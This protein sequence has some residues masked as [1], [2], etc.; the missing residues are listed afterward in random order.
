LKKCAVADFE[1]I[2]ANTT[3]VLESSDNAVFLNDLLPFLILSDRYTEHSIQKSRGS[4]NQYVLFS[5]IAEFEFDLPPLDEQHRLAEV[6]WAFDATKQAYK[7]LLKSTDELVK[8]QFVEMFG[9]DEYPVKRLD[10]IADS[11]LGKMLDAKRQTGKNTYSYLANFNVQWFHF[12]LSKLN[13]M[14]FDEADRAEF[15]LQNGDLLVCEG[16]EVGRTAIWRD[17]LEDCY[18]QKAIH[19]VRCKPSECI[20]EYLAW[21]FYYKATTTQFDGLVSAATIAHLPGE[22]LKAL[23][24]TVPPLDLQNRFAEF[25]KAADKSKFEL[26]RTIDELDAT[27]KAL[28]REKLG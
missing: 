9:S 14:D 17:D 8:S 15:S 26:T 19:R 13:Q 25:A 16:G 4:V 5:D 11:R 2:C 21:A 20:P 10:E 24:F 12:D 22:K 23:R 3:F 28:V 18:F 7:K 27:Y 1:G 6:L